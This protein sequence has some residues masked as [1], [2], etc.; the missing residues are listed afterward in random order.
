MNTTATAG[1]SPETLRGR[2]VDR[3]KE[4]G[5]ARAGPVEDALRTVPRHQFVP[6]ATFEDAY[7][8]IAVITKRGADGAALSCASVPTIVATMLDQLDVRPGHRILEIGAGT[9]YNAALLAQLTG[10]SGQVSTVDIDPEVTT[11]ARRAL[12]TTG[13]GR[14][15]VITGDGAL[16][17]AEHAPYDPHHRDRGGMGPPGLLA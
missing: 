14:V 2:M 7:A 6:D 5:H 12:D 1:G 9:G 11:R 8:D 16:G 3:I 10:P 13:Y 15:Q 17:G 4:A